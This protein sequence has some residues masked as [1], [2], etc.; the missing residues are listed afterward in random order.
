MRARLADQI[1]ASRIQGRP[2]RLLTSAIAAGVVAVSAVSLAAPPPGEYEVK[3]AFLYNFARFVEWPAQAQTSGAVTLCILGADPFGADADMIAG[4]PV[5]QARLRVKRVSDDQ[6]A[7][8]QIL[9]VASSERARLDRVLDEVKGRPVLTVG[10][11]PGFAERG[12]VL[13]FYLEQNK[14]RFEVNIDAARRT[15]L[16]ISSRL[17]RLARV[18]H[19]RTG[20]NG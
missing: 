11:S 19:D 1:A 3:A 12:A 9:F 18:T 8:C 20:S 4:K 14:V 16:V 13:N 2:R 6:A 7:A 17:L 5:G 10:D 15:G